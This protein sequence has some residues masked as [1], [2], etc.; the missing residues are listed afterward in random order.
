MAVSSNSTPCNLTITRITTS[1]SAQD[2][3][4]DGDRIVYSDF[5]NGKFQICMYNFSTSEKS[6]IISSKISV[7]APDIYGDRIVWCEE[8]KKYIGV[9]EE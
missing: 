3:S 5:R 6:V 7:F 2:P 1:G 8:F 4:I 9:V